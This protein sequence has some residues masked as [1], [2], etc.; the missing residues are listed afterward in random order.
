M[1]AN[2]EG[3]MA[4][5]EDRRVRRTRAALRQAMV[6][7]VVERGYDR[8]T[9]R[10]VLDRA[11]IG[12]ST[13]YA[14]YRDK[15]ALFASCFE[16]L[17]EGLQREMALLEGGRGGG[18]ADPI[19]PISVIFEHAHRH[20]QIYRAVGTT[21]LHQMIFEVMRDHLCTHDDLRLPVDVAAEY[22]A[23]ALVGIL[24]W[25]VRAGFPHGPAEM[26]RMIRELTAGGL[27]HVTAP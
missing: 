11:D 2:L 6:E 18:P 26:A 17:R 25:W 14:H 22:H 27:G 10:D 15:D 19:K 16:D 4:A 1:P 23:S 5:V 13:F 12:R 7:L 9:V 20:P 8:V 24:G 3:E 21:H